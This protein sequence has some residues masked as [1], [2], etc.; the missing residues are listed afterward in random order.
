[1]ESY[2]VLSAIARLLRLLPFARHRPPAT[3][4][5]IKEIIAQS[6]EE[7]IITEDEEVMIT[8]I[9]EIGE[10]P[11]EN[12]MIPRVD[13]VCVEAEANVDDV[14][15]L[16]HEKGYSRIPVYDGKI[17]DVIGII[18]VKEL[19]RFWGSGEDLRAIEFIRLP[20]FV[21]DSKRVLDAIREFQR[22]RISIAM[23]IDEY[24]G[25]SG[26]VT[27][28]DLIEEIVGDLRDELDHEEIVHR[29]MGDG[30]YIVN[31][32][33]ELDELNKLLGTELAEEDLH[34]LGGWI[35]SRLERIPATGEKLTI[36]SVAIEVI[37]AST[38]RIYRVRI[39]KQPS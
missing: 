33:M 2:R 15:R 11:V 27:I 21:P 20:Y 30:S 32:G 23:V 6:E 13:M 34:T 10:T 8:K 37:E 35:A 7:G 22:K 4:D 29:A 5:E 31:A 12:V 39:R 9:F 26:L 18:H 16:Y 19:L 36:D 24:G 38:Q 3:E 14:L 1:M 25:I 28:E 17:D